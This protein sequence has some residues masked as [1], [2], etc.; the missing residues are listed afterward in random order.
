MPA[1]RQP[2]VPV[3]TL[4]SGSGSDSIV[5]TGAIANASV[6]L[7]AGSDTLTLGNFTNTAT[8]ANTETIT[9]CGLRA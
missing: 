8:V 5:L 4:T 7:G 6:D 1:I 3:D 2:S 9:G